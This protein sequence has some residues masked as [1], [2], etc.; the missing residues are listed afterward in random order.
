M[1][2]LLTILLT[3]SLLLS[4][5]ACGSKE[6]ASGAADPGGS[7]TAQEPETADPQPSAGDE[8]P[9]S[10]SEPEQTQ[11]TEEAPAEDTAEPEE[12]TEQ[13]PEKEPEK[14][15]EKQPEK[16]PDSQPAQKPA[17]E[18]PAEKP[19][20][21]P[22]K[23]AAPA[24]PEET[25]PAASGD[26]LSILTAVWNAYSVAEKF[27]ATEDAPISMDISNTD[28][29]SYLL[30]FPAEDAALIDGAASLTHMMNLNTFT[31]GAFHAV[32]AQDVT[33]LADDLHTAIADKQWMCGFPDKLVIVTLDQYVIS[34]YGHEE[35]INTFRD[36]LQAA[37]PSADI[38]YEEAIL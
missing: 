15:P 27:P 1:K 32:S 25:A 23:P 13:T 35:L 22:A 12:K 24:Q 37:Y 18:K 31:S 14:T 21:K 10:T 19:T 30:T 38:A 17:Q 4:L 20:E 36:K 33:K 2:R 26:A 28:N 9:G 6:S 29:I 16:Q 7:V 3:L 34:M 5:T 8:Q 11:P